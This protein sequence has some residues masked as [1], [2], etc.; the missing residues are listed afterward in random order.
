MFKR[1]VDIVGDHEGVDFLYSS[2][3][4]P[5]EWSALTDLLGPYLND[6]PSNQSEEA[7]Q[8]ALAERPGMLR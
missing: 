8:R 4:T 2:D 5:E 6:F 7:R 3:W 1:Y